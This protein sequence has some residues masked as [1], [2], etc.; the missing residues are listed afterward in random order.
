MAGSHEKLHQYDT[1]VW[2]GSLVV[3]FEDLGTKWTKAP[4]FVQ[5]LLSLCKVISEREPLPNTP[6]TLTRAQN[7]KDS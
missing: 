1:Y 6:L 2:S 7:L 5:L 3:I 4:N